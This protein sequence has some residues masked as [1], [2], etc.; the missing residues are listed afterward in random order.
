MPEPRPDLLQLMATMRESLQA[1]S[2]HV[3][4]AGQFE[5]R[6]LIR[7][8]D[9]VRREVEVGPVARALEQDTLRSLL[10]VT[11]THSDLATLSQQLCARLRAGALQPDDPELLSQL[12]A[13]VLARLAIDNPD[14]K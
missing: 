2:Q 14:F 6:V 9:I 4:E 7:A 5:L 13:C 3:S 10:G 12:R 1:L 8:L 11:D